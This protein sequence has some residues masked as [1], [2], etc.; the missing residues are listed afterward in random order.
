MDQKKKYTIY[1]ALVLLILSSLQAYYIYNKQAREI[2]DS[3]MKIMDEFEDENDEKI[4]HYF[5]EMNHEKSKQFDELNIL[6]NKIKLNFNKNKPI[7]DSLLTEFTEENGFKIALRNQVY[8][9]YDAVNKKELIDNSPL[10]LYESSLEIKNSNNINLSSWSSNQSIN[11]VDKRKGLNNSEEHF[12]IIKSRVDYDFLNTDI[13]ILKKII[14][15]IFISLLIV[16]VILYLYWK[17]LK[18]IDEQQEKINQ[19]HLNIDSIAHELNTPITT[20]KFAAKQLQKDEN[21]LIIN[22]QINRLENTIEAILVNPQ[23]KSELLNEEDLVRSINEI[24]NRNLTIEIKSDV[25]FKE[26]KRILCADF[27]LILTNLIEN[28]I[29]YGASK[30]DLKFSFDKNIELTFVDDGIGIPEE[31]LPFVF[32]KYY[33]VNRSINQQVNGLGVGLYLVKNV[34]TNYHGQIFVK[35]NL[36]N[37][38]EFKILFSNEN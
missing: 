16:V 1:F 17:S 8:S 10:N 23:S 22:R 26:N 36:Q 29:K 30:I 5:K 9:V 34:V 25:I 37:G 20:L 15:L 33:R 31:D 7:I 35:N 27:Q 21:T 11:E 12:Y 24:Q 18:N 38:V 6:R 32:D 2:A 3:V 19:L 28:S 14:P 4:L 13:L